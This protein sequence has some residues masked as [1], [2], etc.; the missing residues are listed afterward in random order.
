M[1]DLREQV[2][3]MIEQVNTLLDAHDYDKAFDLTNR[4]LVENAPLS[5]DEKVDPAAMGFIDHYYSLVILY[6]NRYLSECHAGKHGEDK[7]DCLAEWQKWLAR[8]E[9]GHEL[10]RAAAAL[11]PNYPPAQ[12]VLR[13]YDNIPPEYRSR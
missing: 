6:A 1:T 3:E 8:I 13:D 5:A 9:T 12:G 7:R 4:M 11:L 2:K 10:A